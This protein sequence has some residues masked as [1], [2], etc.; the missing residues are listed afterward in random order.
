MVFVGFVYLKR[1]NHSS[2]LKHFRTK[3][4][5]YINGYTSSIVLFAKFLQKRNIILSAICPTL[6]V[7]MV[8]SE[9]LFEDDKILLE[10]QFGIPIV[11]EYC[12]SELD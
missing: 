2:F 12:A 9:M 11:N 8:T 5:D 7:C 6:K 1:V 10:K 4:F 3:K